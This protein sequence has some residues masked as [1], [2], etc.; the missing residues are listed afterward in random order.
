LY[1]NILSNLGNYGQNLTAISEVFADDWI[2]RPNPVKALTSVKG[3]QGDIRLLMDFLAKMMPD[4]KYEM[5]QTFVTG[6]TV[7]VVSK[8]SG[9]IAGVPPGFS[10][11][12]MFPGTDPEILK[13][14][15]FNTMAIDIHKLDT[16]DKIKR[17]WHVEDWSLVLDDI[18]KPDRVAAFK[19]P[20]VESGASLKKVPQCII[21]FYDIILS[22][23]VGGGQDNALLKKTMHGDSIVH[24]GFTTFETSG[25]QGLKLITGFFGDVMPNINYERKKE[26]F[27]EDMVV[28]LSKVSATVAGARRG[29][30]EILPFPGINPQDLTGEKFET[31]GISVHRIVDNKIKQTYHIDEWQLAVGQMLSSKPVPDFGFDQL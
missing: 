26:W 13:G 7:V 20:A 1:N 21:D 18:L 22:D 25:I 12:P 6:N 28:V 3:F 17:T 16:E 8:I 24:P 30:K 5:L 2:Y 19:W 4:M 9:T 29:D 27:H 23:P 11:F 31:L 14:K 15:S 10:D